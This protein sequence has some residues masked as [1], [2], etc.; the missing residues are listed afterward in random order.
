MRRDQLLASILV[1]QFLFQVGGSVN[2]GFG[3]SFGGGV[4]RAALRDRAS[5]SFGVTRCPV[6]ANSGHPMKRPLVPVALAYAAGLLGAELVQP[7]LLVLLACALVLL[8]A[9]G[10]SATRRAFLLWPLLILVGWANLVSRTA[11]LS[12]VDL[13]LVA[14]TNAALVTVRGRLIATPTERVFERDAV[15]AWRTLAEIS[16]AEIQRDGRWQPAVGRVMS[17]TTGQLPD[18]YFSGQSVEVA[19]VLLQPGFPLAEGLFDYRTYLARQGIYYQLRCDSTNDW[20]LGAGARAERPFSDRFLDWAQATLARG[21][22]SE[23]RDQPLRLLWAM[24]L[25]WR[26][27]LTNEVSEPFMRSG[28]MHIFAVSGLH[29]ALIAGI[30]VSLL[31]VAQLP[32][33]WCGLVV[34]PLIWF[35]TQA[36]GWQPSA[37]RS[38]VMMTIII[39]GWSL[40]RPTD[41]I[42]SLAAAA[43][44]ILIW[45]PQQ[46]FQASFQLSF[47]VVLS[48][49]LFLPPLEKLRSR[50]LQHDPLLPPSLIPRWQRWLDQ[51]LRWVSVA[52]ATSVAAWLGSLPL[53][54]CYFH[55]FSPVTLLANLLIVPASSAALACNLGSLLCGDWLPWV[56][57]LFNHV[58]WAAMWF[59][60]WFSEWVTRIPGAFVYVPSPGWLE[61]IAYYA[62]LIGTLG[63]WLWRKAVR[64]WSLA[65]LA[66][67]LLFYAARWLISRE[68][69]KLTVLPLN[70]AHAVQLDATGRANDW[71][72]DCGN[73]NSVAFVT[74]PFLRAQ[75]VNHLPRLLLTHGDLKHIGGTEVLEQEFGVDAFFTS[76]VRFRSQTYRR[77]LGELAGHPDRHRVIHR[78]DTSGC[79]RVL[80]PEAA[81]KFAQG[82][83]SA[84]VLLGD[85]HGTHVLLLSDLGR[86]GQEALFNRETALRADIV[87]AGLPE[88]AEPVNDSLLDQLQPKVLIIADSEYPAPRRASPQLRDRLARRNFPVLYTRSTG[89][90]TVRL[91]KHGWGL[92][93][94][95]GV[96]LSP[97]AASANPASPSGNNFASPVE[98]GSER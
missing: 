73:T 13:R 61:F 66:L 94:M 11:I 39:G 21:L 49:A 34:I 4:R 16:V 35:Y 50:L 46:L 6:F 30:F 82:D 32:R 67:L 31:R 42:N 24:T 23:A 10:G 19:G 26:P 90:V 52:L 54:A 80:H 27:A 3:F 28:T 51:P 81:D 45:D 41:L 68:D 18:S 25:G 71:L 1:T 56:G 95:N 8:L 14:G 59:M 72:I 88:R 74:K 57:E 60:S 75:G 64:P 83:D 53:T 76:G 97:R 43:F 47:F 29:I 86:L 22:P 77:L 7:R 87:V 93:T 5:G 78:G 12:P 44:A 96:T 89:A 85:F 69:M 63:G 65:G 37:I 17:T 48:I 38:T 84:L 92:S 91:G 40:G 33:G 55:L 98:A 58:G 20:R 36:T 15:E 70:G 62:L 9:A 79:W 2:S